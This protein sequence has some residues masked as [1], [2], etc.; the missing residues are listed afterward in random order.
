MNPP[1][2]IPE[3]YQIMGIFEIPDNPRPFIPNQKMQLKA[4]IYA[5]KALVQHLS[6]RLNDSNFPYVFIPIV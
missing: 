5:A 3:F 2:A 1:R 6:E 4:G